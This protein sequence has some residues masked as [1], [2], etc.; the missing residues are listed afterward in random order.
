M[1]N[2]ELTHYQ[3]YRGYLF[4]TQYS[5]KVFADLAR[6]LWR[7][8]RGEPSRPGRP[9]ASQ[10]RERRQKLCRRCERRIFAR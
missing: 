4:V 1:N 6:L 2:Q 7:A 10:G 3:R 9:W 5:C 8:R